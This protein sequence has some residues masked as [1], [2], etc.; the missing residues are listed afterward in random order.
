[1]DDRV[2]HAHLPQWP[3][4]KHLRV[5][6]GLFLECSGC[7][8]M[9]GLY[10][11]ALPT[12][13]TNRGGHFQ[14]SFSLKRHTQPTSSPILTLAPSLA[15]G[16]LPLLALALLA[17]AS[18]GPRAVPLPLNSH[19]APNSDHLTSTSEQIKTLRAPGPKD[20]V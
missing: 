1:M 5:G 16:V 14:F 7:H 6:S 19:T 15:S 4:N 20:K 9:F 13:R 2:P 8:Y 18:P 17:P 3:V 11:L 10:V 12:L